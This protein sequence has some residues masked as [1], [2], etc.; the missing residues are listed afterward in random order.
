MS[1]G[2]STISTFGQLFPGIDSGI[3]APTVVVTTPTDRIYPIPG[4][5]RLMAIAEEPRTMPI[6][7]E[8]RTF[9]VDDDAS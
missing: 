1:I 8:N 9:A 4:E 3:T 5:L 6:D 7:G 2:R